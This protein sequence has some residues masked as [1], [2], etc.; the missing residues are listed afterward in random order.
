MNNNLLQ[1]KIKQ[2]LNKLASLDYDNIECW[3]IAEAFNKAQIE[4]VRRQLQGNNL[5]KQGDESTIMLIDDLQTLLTEVPMTGTNQDLHFETTTLPSNYL[6]FKSL[7]IDSRT[8]CCPDAMMSCYL[9][10]VADVSSLLSDPF[11]K[12][13]ADWGETFVTMQGNRLRIYH[14]DEF[15]VINPRLTFYRFPIPVS[16]LNCVNPATGAVTANVE[17]E[18]KDDIVEMIIDEA[19]SILA[20]D[21]ELFNQYQRAKTNAQTN[22]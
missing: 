16:F 13:S 19:A 10:A 2:R 4:W 14:N 5:R 7:V 12:P 18:L 20:G 15:Q 17:S 11:R 8:E 6:H 9:V 21:T 22:N 1:I 3:Q